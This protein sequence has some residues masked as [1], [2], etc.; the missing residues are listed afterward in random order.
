MSPTVPLRVTLKHT[1]L[2]KAQRAFVLVVGGVDGKNLRLRLI[3]Q[4]S[5]KM[6]E[7]WVEEVTVSDKEV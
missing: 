4:Q 7:N 2:L 6:R 1:S 5:K 3:P